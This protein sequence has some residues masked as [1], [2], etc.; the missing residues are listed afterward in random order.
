[1]KIFIEGFQKLQYITKDSEVL[2]HVQGSVHIQ[3]R[4]C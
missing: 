2:V 4:P 1:M 3:K